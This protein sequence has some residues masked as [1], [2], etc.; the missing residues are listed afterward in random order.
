[1]FTLELQKGLKWIN[2]L[3]KEKQNKSKANRREV[4]K[5]MKLK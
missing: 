2:T 3:E 5:K 4:I 1:M